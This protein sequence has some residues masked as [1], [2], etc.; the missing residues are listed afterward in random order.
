MN[1]TKQTP[2]RWRTLRWSSIGLFLAIAS[3]APLAAQSGNDTYRYDDKKGDDAG[4]ADGAYGR[5]QFADNGLTVRRSVLTDNGDSGSD[6]GP[7]TPIYPGDTLL[8]GHDQRGEVELGDGSLV[9]FD[10]GSELTFLSMPSPYAEIQDNTIL[11]LSTGAIR[12]LTLTDFD[13]DGEEFRID[14]PTASIYVLDAG[15][16]RIEVNA[17]G[18]TDVTSR[19]GVAELVGTDGAVIVR[20]GTRSTVRHAS[21]PTRPEPFNTFVSDSF[22]RWV[23]ERDDFYQ[24][25]DRY[26]GNSGDG[27]YDSL[28]DEV[29]P[30]YR[31]LS[32]QGGWRHTA[33][34]GW[35]W[36][37]HDVP[38][39]WRPYR[40]G[41]WDYG[42]G[43]YFWVS[44]E[45][46]GWAPYRYGRWN[47]VSGFG[48]S[49]CPGRVFGGAWV[50]WSWG[51]VHVGWT[52]LNY[53]NQ[54]C[55]AG[56][57]YYGYY[58]PY[59]WT[60]VRYGHFRHR[61]SD[62]YAVPVHSIRDELR[63]SA[64]ST[65]PPRVAPGRLANSE[66]ARREAVLRVRGDDRNRINPVVRNRPTRD[67][68]RDTDRIVR[69]QI[70]RGD[71][72]RGDRFSGDRTPTTRG[73]H[74][75]TLTRPGGD[76][77]PSSARPERKPRVE[78]G[79]DSRMR[80]IYDRMSR[81][82]TTRDRTDES[83]DRGRSSSAGSTAERRPSRRPAVENNRGSDSSASSRS[84]S[85]RPTTP[86]RQPSSQPRS[87]PQP[88]RQP[89]ARPKTSAPKSRGTSTQARSPRGGSKSSASGRS[90]SGSKPRSSSSGRS[91]GSRSSGGKKS[92]GARSSRSRGR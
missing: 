90:S 60:F 53:W 50:A 64:V 32:S 92:S 75:R 41:R 51:N 11:Q 35:V 9:R 3:L 37:P 47:W 74:A 71:L 28:P 49:W 85:A 27:A 13:G 56:P 16:L 67:S 48:W 69:D 66:S 61:Y 24:S 21:R 15:D 1:S 52:A 7:N 39:G 76:N 73:A 5:I 55:Y 8:T 79:D 10:R 17:N 44:S 25:R 12:I 78:T 26:A 72:Q 87:T 23:D 83:A 86:R 80:T 14:T 29:R 91:S 58:D 77:R 31:E 36:S 18:V 34:Y 65:R 82:R 88:R 38:A 54:P 84:R 62:R 6:V 68:V 70:S 46:W 30:Y 4:Y 19:R 45:P 57:I 40:L 42:P 81:P 89:T 22:D 20:A 2:N 33:D 63:G 59:A 43:G